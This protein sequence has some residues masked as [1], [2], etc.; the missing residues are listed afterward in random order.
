MKYVVD[1]VDRIKA[2]MYDTTITDEDALTYTFNHGYEKLDIIHKGGG[3]SHY[4]GAYHPDVICETGTKSDTGICIWCG[5]T[6]M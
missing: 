3:T 6:L 5:R 4:A 1:V 2:L